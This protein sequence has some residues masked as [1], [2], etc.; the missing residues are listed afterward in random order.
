MRCIA[1]G[2]VWK[3]YGGNVLF[4]SYCE[5]DVLRSRLNAEGFSYI[6]IHKP[7]PH[8]SDLDS[9]TTFLDNL[10][11]TEQRDRILVALDGYHFDSYYQRTIKNKGIRL[12]CIDDYGHADQYYADVILNQNLSAGISLY[13]NCSPHTKFFL[14]PQYVLLRKEFWNWKTW[15]RDILGVAKKVLVTM[16]G[17]DP[18]NVTLKVLKA[19]KEVAIPDM[20]VVVVLGPAN[21]HKEEIERSLS[22]FPFKSHL[23]LSVDNMPELMAWADMAIAA[24]GSTGWELV[25]M[26]LP[27]ILLI[28]A[29]NQLAVSHKLEEAGASINLGWYD[30][31]TISMIV[32]AVESL[33]KNQ[34]I[35]KTMSIKG[36]IL[37]DGNGG[38]KV[39]KFLMD[40][41]VKFRQV[42][43]E[44][45][46]LVWEWANDSDT[47][48]VSFSTDPISWE[49]HV[50][51]FAEKMN[52]AEYVFFII[53]SFDDEPVGQVRYAVNGR[54][55]FISMSIAPKFRGRGYASRS[56]RM[57]AEE[58]F[59]RAD[60]SGIKAHIK[61]ENSRSIQAFTRAGFREDNST[62]SGR[63]N[64]HGLKFFI[65]RGDVL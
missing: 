21:P 43:E 14:G 1:L 44:D 39:L 3:E 24:G 48:A 57:T 63:K 38:S 60:V 26:G 22:L 16:G 17:A 35:R 62:A 30:K 65:H 46:R 42:C 55:A 27:S 28:L 29:E 54:E 33:M 40:S 49:D 59:R 51:W 23:L 31:A 10:C 53:L 56:I 4:A 20:E 34:E 32:K 64:N 19:L 9:I 2:Q 11:A 8:P 61:P 13:P 15:K 50:R 36:R 52:D 5:S 25:F 58:L 41:Y 18:D 37:V 7:H 47:R 12:L 6:P 45:C